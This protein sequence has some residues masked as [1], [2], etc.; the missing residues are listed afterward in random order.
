[1]LDDVF[2]GVVD[3]KNCNEFMLYIVI[4]YIYGDLHKNAPKNTYFER[5]TN[6]R[7]PSKFFYPNVRNPIG[8]EK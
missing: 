5:V 2:Y 7:L 4:L 3:K 8:R 6:G 1:M